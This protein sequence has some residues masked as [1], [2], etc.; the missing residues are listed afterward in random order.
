MINIVIFDFDGVI[1]ESAPYFIKRY[2]KLATTYNK[3]FDVKNMEEFRDW[4]D[5]KWENNYFTMGF[6]KEELENAIFKTRANVDYYDIPHYQGI[7]KVF[8]IL[9]KKYILTLAS[10]TCYS[11]LEKK[12][13]EIDSLKYISYISP[14]DGHGSDKKEIIGDV[15]KHFNISPQNAIMVG[16]TEMDIKSALANGIKGIGTAYGWQNYKKLEKA[17]AISIAFKPEDI[18]DLV[19]KY[20][21]SVQ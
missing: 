3:K 7:E 12:L 14:G 19:E 2:R 10:C 16:D 18:I 8:E 5:S 1:V 6:T 21:E 9:S 20:F 17:G 13:K 11:E 4:Y 15:I